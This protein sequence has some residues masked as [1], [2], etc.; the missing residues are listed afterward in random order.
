MKPFL[1]LLI[2]FQSIIALQVPTI[3]KVVALSDTSVQVSWHSNDPSVTGFYILRVDP[4]MS[5]PWKIDTLAATE[6][7]YIDMHVEP[8]ETYGYGVAAFSATESAYPSSYTSVTLPGIRRIFNLPNLYTSWDTVSSTIKV[9]IQDNATI[10]TGYRVLKSQ[11]FGPFSELKT[12]I[13]TN[14]ALMDTISCT[15]NSV[16]A[17]AWYVYR[18]IVYNST[19]KDSTETTI[20]AYPKGNART[21]KKL[22]LGAK[23]SDFPIRLGSWAL[24]QGDTICVR[25]DSMPWDSCSLINVVDKNKPVSAGRIL[26]KVP[27]RPQQPQSYASLENILLYRNG[28]VMVQ[29]RFK[30]GA[31]D[32]LRSVPAYPSFG[33]G[34]GVTVGQVIGKIN[35]HT[36]LTRYTDKKYVYHGINFVSQDSLVLLG[37]VPLAAWGFCSEYRFITLQA[38]KVCEYLVAGFQNGSNCDLSTPVQQYYF[39]YD[40]SFDPLAAVQSPPQNPPDTTVREI[41]GYLTQDSL[42]KRSK[43][44]FVDS[45]RSLIYLFGDTT[46]SVYS[47]SFETG[48]SKQPQTSAPVNNSLSIIYHPS[49]RRLTFTFSKPWYGSPT[50]VQLYSPNGKLLFAKDAGRERSVRVPDGICGVVIVKV[51]SGNEKVEKKIFV[52]K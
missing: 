10:E 25:Q 46:M 18:A 33:T 27:S 37:A 14:P 6:S 4:M 29:Y 49:E 36:V 50:M 23:L 1:L 51:V 8:A 39:S 7:T 34:P 40:F 38:G 43:A 42:I 41:D 24:K 9:K 44:V 52:V 17:G 11:N 21:T 26:D 32:S 13:S 28:G 2:A 19:R 22:S 45:A 30:N 20:Y 31:I 48:I 3:K 35:E 16:Q 12:L 15:D 5:F 47:F